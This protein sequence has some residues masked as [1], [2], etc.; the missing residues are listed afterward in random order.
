VKWITARGVRA[1]RMRHQRAT[2][3]D[4][5]DRL[6]AGNSEVNG[7]GGKQSTRAAEPIGNT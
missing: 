6:Q 2:G 3:W 4:T 1:A 7:V 5:R